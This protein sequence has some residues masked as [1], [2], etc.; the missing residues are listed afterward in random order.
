VANLHFKYSQ[1]PTHGEAMWNLKEALKTAGWVHQKSSQGTGGGFTNTAGNENDVLTASFKFNAAGA[2]WVGRSPDPTYRLEICFQRLTTVVYDYLITTTPGAYGSGGLLTPPVG[3]SGT[4]VV[5][6][7]SGFGGQIFGTTENVYR[8]KIMAQNASPWGWWMW[9]HP[10]GGGVG[11]TGLFMDPMRSLSYPSEDNYPQVFS[12][13]L[14]NS[15]A[16]FKKER[17]AIEGVGNTNPGPCGHLGAPTTANGFYSWKFVSG[18]YYR[19]IIRDIEPGSIGVNPHS[20]Y[21][22]MLP[23][24]YARPAALTSKNGYKGISSL[25]QWQAVSRN[26]GDTMSVLSSRDKI[27]LGDVVADWDGTIPEV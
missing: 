27:V 21:D 2:W 4:F 6:G 12:A 26:P 15:A 3:G 8:Q 5:I 1:P 11:Y 14:A 13:Q 24:P 18:M 16:A 9:G 17:L 20:G 19:N 7:Q 25:F 10:I 22:D 23:M